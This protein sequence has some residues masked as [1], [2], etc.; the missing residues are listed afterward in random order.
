RNLDTSIAFF[1]HAIGDYHPLEG[2]VYSVDGLTINT[3]N[4][5]STF[6]GA[7]AFTVTIGDAFGVSDSQ[8][9]WV[10]WGN[11]PMDNFPPLF[12][13]TP[14]SSMAAGTTRMEPVTSTDMNGDEVTYTLVSGPT[15]MSLVHQP[16]N[17]PETTL[18]GWYVV[19]EPTVA[20]IT[21]AGSP[22][23]YTIR[24]N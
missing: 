16:L 2:L 5:S 9:F 20:Q 18:P 21:P 14:P 12:T 4:I 6:V 11:P 24:A 22:A 10:I 23:T 17:S 15:G 7:V 1:A 19:W 8:D 3:L 13:L